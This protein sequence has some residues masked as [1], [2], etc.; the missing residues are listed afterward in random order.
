MMQMRTAVIPENNIKSCKRN[1]PFFQKMFLS[2]F[3]PTCIVGASETFSLYQGMYIVQPPMIYPGIIG[4]RQ[5][6]N[7]KV[8]ALSNIF[9]PSS[10]Q[11]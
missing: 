7:A 5:F 6:A 3:P 11:G 10:R 9:Q 4:S 8:N 2:S 1:D